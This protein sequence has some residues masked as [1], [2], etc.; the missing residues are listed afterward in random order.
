MSSELD[1]IFNK[2]SGWSVEEIQSIMYH[3]EWT[4]DRGK[5]PFKHPGIKPAKPRSSF[6]NNRD[7]L[8]A[9]LDQDFEDFTTEKISKIIICSTFLLMN[10][11][12]KVRH[13]YL[14]EL[15]N[16]SEIKANLLQLFETMDKGWSA[17]S[18]K[19]TKLQLFHALCKQRE[20]SEFKIKKVTWANVTSEW[21]PKIVMTDGES[22]YYI[23]NQRDDF[24]THHKKYN[25][26]ATLGR[27]EQYKSE[28]LEQKTDF[29]LNILKVNATNKC[30]TLAEYFQNN[31]MGSEK[32][33]LNTKLF[34]RLSEEFFRNELE[35]K[36]VV[37]TD[38]L[39]K[40]LPRLTQE[41]NTNPCLSSVLSPEKEW[42]IPRTKVQAGKQDFF[43]VHG[44]EW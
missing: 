11:K 1:T 22:Y 5:T 18:Q 7:E 43:V 42:V 14:N 31:N 35:T 10:D 8:K 34:E 15:V 9:L 24:E 29:N 30:T 25:I 38:E 4:R 39:R 26:A 33:E 32:N 41:E 13:E 2:I 27:T 16:K 40:I 20:N 19:I 21:G 23:F 12:D 37:S 36:L 44:D 28:Y 3:E 6:T 17:S